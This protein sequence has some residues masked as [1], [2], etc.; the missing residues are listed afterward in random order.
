MLQEGRPYP[1]I[2]VGKILKPGKGFNLVPFA[3]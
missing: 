3:G 2:L 1:L